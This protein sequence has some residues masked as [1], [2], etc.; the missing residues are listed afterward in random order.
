MC[1]WQGVVLGVECDL[2]PLIGK[3]RSEVELFGGEFLTMLLSSFGIC[4]S[5]V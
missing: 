1:Q 4:I 3:L 2:I 5:L